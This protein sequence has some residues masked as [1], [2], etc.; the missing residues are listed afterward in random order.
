MNL[1]FLSLLKVERKRKKVDMRTLFSGRIKVYLD[2]KHQNYNV[3]FYTRHYWSLGRNIYGEWTFSP[4]IAWKCGCIFS[5]YKNNLNL[6]ILKDNFR[7]RYL[8]L[9]LDERLIGNLISF[10]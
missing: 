6:E 4:C 3:R 9:R 7:G 1:Y 5:Y 10:L 2:K 8:F